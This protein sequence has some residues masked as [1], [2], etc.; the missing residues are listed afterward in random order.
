M[1]TTM[2]EMIYVTPSRFDH[3]AAARVI[4]LAEGLEVIE[5]TLLNNVVEAYEAKSSLPQSD[6]SRAHELFAFYRADGRP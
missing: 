1:E 5:R 6:L 4:A 2:T 3:D